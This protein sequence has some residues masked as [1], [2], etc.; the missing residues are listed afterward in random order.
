MAGRVRFTQFRLTQGQEK[1]AREV[2]REL[3]VGQGGEQ[4]FEGFLLLQDPPASFAREQVLVPA[5]DRQALGV[6]TAAKQRF[7]PLAEFGARAVHSRSS[8]RKGA[9]SVRR[10]SRARWIRDLIAFSLEL[11]TLA[12]ST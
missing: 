5:Q 8:S 6:G 4:Q 2:G 11:R 12:I 10:V 9:S 3:R 7:Q 1:P